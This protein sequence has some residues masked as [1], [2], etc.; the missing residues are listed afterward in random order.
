MQGDGLPNP[1]PGLG[2]GIDGLVLRDGRGLLVYNHSTVERTPLNVALSEDGRTWRMAAVLEDA[3]GEY[4]YP[5]VIQ[6]V[7]G[8]VHVVYTWQRRRIKHAVVDAL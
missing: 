6:G 4:S 8:R 5:A 3:P 2:S 1:N 7:D